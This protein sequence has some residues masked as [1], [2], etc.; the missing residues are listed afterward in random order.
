MRKVCKILNI[1]WDQHYGER[2]KNVTVDD[3]KLAFYEMGA[4]QISPTLD[5]F[6]NDRCYEP[7]DPKGIP[8]W[9]DAIMLGDNE[10]EVR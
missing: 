9:C 4:T 8:S 6:F 1:T 7:E 3:L 2:L 5:S 10:F